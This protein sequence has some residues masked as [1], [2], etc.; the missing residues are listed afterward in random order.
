MHELIKIFD[1]L[2]YVVI[3]KIYANNK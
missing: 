3:S 1:I 2:L